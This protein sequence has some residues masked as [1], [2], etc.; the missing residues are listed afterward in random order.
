V[1]S[2]LLIGILSVGLYPYGNAQE[3]QL[4]D[5]SWK[6]QCQHGQP[7][8]TGNLIEVCIQVNKKSNWLKNVFNEE[9]GLTKSQADLDKFLIMEFR[10]TNKKVF[11]TRKTI[12]IT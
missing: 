9:L 5:G 1:N 11:V 7:E 3:S 10:L 12:L 4:P 2:I 8:C 6:F